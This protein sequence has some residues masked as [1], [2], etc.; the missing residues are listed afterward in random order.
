MSLEHLRISVFS[1]GQPQLI[2]EI[3]KGAK[4]RAVG[5]ASHS[6]ETFKADVHLGDT[7]AEGI[8]KDKCVPWHPAIGHRIGYGFS[9]HRGNKPP[10][11]FRIQ[12]N[13]VLLIHK[14]EN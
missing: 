1:N 4:I 3:R 6:D 9:R 14:V 5:G 13:P 10:L 7:L 8:P 2:Y 12:E 11:L